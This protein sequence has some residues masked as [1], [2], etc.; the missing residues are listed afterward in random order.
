MEGYKPGNHCC[1]QQYKILPLNPVKVT[2]VLQR[3]EE[4][5]VGTFQVAVMNIWNQ[6]GDCP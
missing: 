3:Q 4:E 2:E 1:S 6:L 5:A